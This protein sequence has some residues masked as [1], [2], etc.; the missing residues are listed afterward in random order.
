M[1]V[2]VF[3]FIFFVRRKANEIERRQR[4]QMVEILYEITGL[5]AHIP[6]SFS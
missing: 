1:Y 2:C 5:H 6:C 4:D 3:V